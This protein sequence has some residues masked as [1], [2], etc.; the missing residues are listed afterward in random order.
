M[1]RYR[2][3]EVI[4]PDTAL[5]P[6][7][8]LAIDTGAHDLGWHTHRRAQLLYHAEGAATLYIGDRVG[9]LAPAQAVWLPGGHP[10]RTAMSGPFAYR[11]LY[12]DERV[13]PDLPKTPGILEVN[14]LM[15]E[16]ILRITDWPSDEALTSPQQR[17]VATLFDELAAAQTAP[18]SLPM[19]HEK[20]LLTIAQALLDDPALPFSLDEWG[21]RVG[22]SERTLA[23]GFV[24]ETSLTFAQWRT[25]CRLMVAQV[26]LAEGMPVTTVAHLIGYAS[27]SAFIAM[28]R[29]FY[30]VPPGRQT[31]SK[32]RA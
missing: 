19:P 17:L 30:G 22:A 29:R 24:R 18:L 2:L 28:Y 11:S 6:V 4:D 26:R 13:Y 9:K 1:P 7:V 8:G 5:C 10:H 23:R 14:A 31:R 15:R 3:D 27:D 21:T 12:F 20:R 32:A 25:H 16:L